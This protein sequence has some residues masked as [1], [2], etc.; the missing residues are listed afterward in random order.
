MT[1]LDTK[2]QSTE[3]NSEGITIIDIVFKLKKG[4]AFFKSK[5][6]LILLAGII[7]GS[8]GVLYAYLQPIKYT[9]TLTFALEEEKGSSGL[10]GALGIANSLGIEIGGS[11]GGAFNGA[12]LIVLM[13]SRMLVEKAL[14]STITVKGKTQTLANYYLTF[15][16]INKEWEKN[17]KIKMI[18]FNPYEDRSK[19]TLQQDSV[20]GNLYAEM[21]GQNGV[22]TVVQKDKKVSILTVDVKSNDELFSKNFTECIAKVVSDFYVDTKSKKAKY[23]FEILQKQTDSVRNE[24]Y[25][26]INGVAL[27]NDNTFNLNPALNVHRTPYARKQ[28]DVQANTAILTQLVTNLEMAKVSLRKETPLIQIIDKPILP[29][30]KEKV[31]KRNALMLGGFLGGVLFIFVFVLQSI[32]KKFGNKNVSD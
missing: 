30:N 16:E 14:L 25:A 31:S 20:L 19:F 21:I 6:I 8:L 3:I 7:G 29:L 27:A 13:K 32:Y 28:I 5:W 17:P 1:Q 23:N 4:I 12:N 10:T 24:L 2:Y 22:L 18:T 26:A 15:M 9:A 11:G